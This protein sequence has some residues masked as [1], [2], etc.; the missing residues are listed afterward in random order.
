MPP[1]TRPSSSAGLSSLAILLLALAGA[2]LAVFFLVLPRMG[3]SRAAGPRSLP[4]EA[5]HEPRSEPGAVE[6]AQP[7]S[8]EPEAADQVET[9]APASATVVREQAPATE[10]KA[11]VE[12]PP[13]RHL[14]AG[15][16]KRDTI[17]HENLK[18]ENRERR[19]ARRE[20]AA[21][22]V[23]EFARDGQAETEKPRPLPYPDRKRISNRGGNGRGQG[24]GKGKP[25][26]S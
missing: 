26:G 23:E 5:Q 4:P 8:L 24:Q 10:E 3:A 11:K 7:M 20:R 9:E 21:S 15:G 1:A 22:G 17:A 19:K 25:K 2:G 18:A 14:K 16:G 12:G 6:L 13:L